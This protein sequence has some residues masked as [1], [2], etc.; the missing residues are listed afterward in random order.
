LVQ[1]VSGI[2]VFRGAPIEKIARE[3]GKI[4]RDHTLLEPIWYQPDISKQRLAELMEQAMR[5]HP[6]CIAL[7]DNNIPSSVLRV[8]SKVHR[9]IGSDKPLW[10]YML[11]LRKLTMKLGMGQHAL[12]KAK[13]AHSS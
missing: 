12:A 3:E 6:N 11:P 7:Q 8:A 10:Q 2:R 13:P 9:M 4:P 5:K 1:L